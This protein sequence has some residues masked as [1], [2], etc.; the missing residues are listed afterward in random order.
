M[1][2]KFLPHWGGWEITTRE[3]FREFTVDGNVFKTGMNPEEDSFYASAPIKDGIPILS[4]ATFRVDARGTIHA[5][6]LV[7]ENFID[8]QDPSITYSGTWELQNVGVLYGGRR[9]ISNIVEDSFTISFFGTSIGLILTRAGNQGRLRIN[10]DGVDLTTVDL[11]SHDA[12]SRS[13]AW[14]KTDMTNAP[15]T[16]RCTIETRNPLATDNRIG[17]QGYTLF[18][19]PGIRMEQL[20][21]DLYSYTTSLATN[22]NGF[23]RGV[24]SVPVGHTVYGIVGMMLTEGVMSDATLTDPKL[25]WRKTEIYLYNGPANTTFGVTITLLLSQFTQ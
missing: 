17:L 16:L 5:K 12:F 15:H 14:K 21:C 20:S 11:Y 8:C 6:R 24:I 1:S 18:P 23:V 7:L 4:D 10:L 25:A 19:N 3:M 9:M 22:A 13:I 2:M